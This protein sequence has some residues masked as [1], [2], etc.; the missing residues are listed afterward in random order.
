MG[1]AGDLAVVEGLRGVFADCSAAFEEQD[2]FAL[3]DELDG[4]RDAS[5][6]RTDDADVCEEVCGRDVVEEVV[7]HFGLEEPLSCRTG[8]LRGAR[9]LR[10]VCTLSFGDDR[11]WSSRWSED[12]AY[13]TH[14]Q[15]IA[16]P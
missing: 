9:A 6:S 7:N 16:C 2:F 4:E 10:D 8:R 3:A 1:E 14:F 12:G 5:G 11:L 15:K 13:S